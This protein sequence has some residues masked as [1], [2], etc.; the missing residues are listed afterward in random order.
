MVASKR[1]DY[2]GSNELKNV[3]QSAY[4]LG[5]LTKTALLLINKDA[6]LTLARGE[7]TA[8]VLHNYWQHLTQ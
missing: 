1:N 3:K 4:K 6:H 2:F 5:H 8:V 7:A